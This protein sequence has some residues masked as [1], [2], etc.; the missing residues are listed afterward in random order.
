MSSS[1]M[2]G[3]WKRKKL[4]TISLEKQ[5]I[6]KFPTIDEEL[7]KHLINNDDQI[8]LDNINNILLTLPYPKQNYHTSLEQM[9]KCRCLQEKKIH[10][11][12][13]QQK[14][15]DFLDEC[16]KVNPNLDK[17]KIQKEDINTILK[18]L[19]LNSKKHLGNLI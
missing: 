12:L 11:K 17:E 6:E 2:N 18:M 10:D 15:I 13:K 16:I 3:I 8:V 4:K 19:V 5:I 9:K 14:Q 7:T 1:D